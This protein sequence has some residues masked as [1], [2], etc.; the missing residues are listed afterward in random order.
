[1]KKNKYTKKDVTEIVVKSLFSSGGTISMK[2]AKELI[3]SRAY[4]EGAMLSKWF[5]K[6][7]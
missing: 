7:E 6:Q 4:N 3:R 5:N 2:D 1:M